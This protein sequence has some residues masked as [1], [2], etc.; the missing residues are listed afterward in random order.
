M[1]SSDLYSHSEQRYWR[2]NRRVNS[3]G[4]FGVDPNRN[5]GYEWGGA[6]ASD[7]PWSNTYRGPEAFSEPC[8]QAIR[9]LARAESLNAS[10][11]Y[12]SYGQ[13][14]LYP[15][16]YGYDESPDDAVFA[17]IA[18]KVAAVNHYTPQQSSALYPSSGDTDDFLYSDH[19]SVS[20]TIELAQDFIPSASQIPEICT[21]NVTAALVFL[22]ESAE[23]FPLVQHQP[24]SG[25]SA[26]STT[27]IQVR[28]IDGAKPGFDVQ[29]VT[30]V[31]HDGAVESSVELLQD[32][33]N[34]GTFTGE[35][36]AQEAGSTI[37]YFFGVSA[38]DGRTGRTPWTH[39][40][41]YQVE[42]AH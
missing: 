42:A 37:E 25:A 39:E 30:L 35:L 38:V 14:I 23:A 6:G 40:W 15:W 33:E 21:A 8:T 36:P 13:L 19:H 18:Q 34:P 20:F 2:K 31:V 28:T 4:S 12:H 5:Y 26:E 32:P 9:D 16:S 29:G 27:P 22:E 1:C 7:S 41:S 17:P 24:V 3:D 11:S 10:I